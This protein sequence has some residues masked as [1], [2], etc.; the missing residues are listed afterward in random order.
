[1]GFLLTWEGQ[2][3]GAIYVSGDT[4]MYGG[5]AEVAAR[6][7]IGAAFLHM[8]GASF[9]ERGL[10]FTMTAADAA[11]AARTLDAKRVFPVHTDG[12]TH[13]RDDAKG[14]VPAFHGAG[15]GERLV[16]WRREETVRWSA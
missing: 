7:A 10:R 12:W 2:R 4:V 13:F 3:D 9:R 5:I 16:D 15:L 6:G 11:R 14:I 8:G 1:V